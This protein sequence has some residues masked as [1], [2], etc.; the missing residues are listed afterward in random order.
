MGHRIQSYPGYKDHMRILGK[1]IIYSFLWYP[2]VL[3]IALIVV[4]EMAMPD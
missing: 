3:V 2:V 1:C 4:F